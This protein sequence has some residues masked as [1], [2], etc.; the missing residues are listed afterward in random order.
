MVNAVEGV[1]YHQDQIYA[2]GHVEHVVKGAIVCLRVLMVT[3]KSVHAMQ[4]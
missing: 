3:M 1:N 4:I 2:R